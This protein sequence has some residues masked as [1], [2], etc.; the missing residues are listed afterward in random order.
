MMKEIKKIIIKILEDN[1][2]I[3]KKSLKERVGV[4]DLPFKRAFSEL[5]RQ[6]TVY[7]DYKNG[8]CHLKSDTRNDGRI[9]NDGRTRDD[10]REKTLISTGNEI[11]DVA[12]SFGLTRDFGEDVLAQTNGC[13]PPGENELASR[14]TLFDKI[15]IT[16]D[17][18]DSKDLDDAVSLETL[19]NGNKILGVHIADVSHY[20]TRGSALDIEARNRGTSVYLINKVIPMLPTKLSNEICSLNPHEPRLTLSCFMEIDH[21]GRVLAHTL[22]KTAI[23]SK[24]RMTYSNVNKIL[25]GNDELRGSYADIVPILE[26]M[27]RLS[28][29]VRRRRQDAGC[30][31][32]E[33]DECKIE[34]DENDMP[35]EIGVRER[36]DAEKLI[37]DFMIIANETV[38]SDFFGAGYP[39]IY[40]VHDRPES[41]KLKNLAEFL[42]TLGIKFNPNRSNGLRG[43]T[44]LGRDN[45]EQA[46]INRMVLRAMQKA[47]YHTK[48]IGHFGL[49]STA[50][51][52]FTSP[53]RRYPDL[54]VH[55]LISARLS[56]EDVKRAEYAGELAVI[57]AHSSDMERNAIDAERAVDA[58]KKTQ[59]M[60]E[61][62]GETFKGVVSGMSA[63]A[64]YVELPNTVEGVVPMRYM[65]DDYYIV[66]RDKYCAIGE[67]TRRRIGLGDEVEVRAEN[68]KLNVPEVVFSIGNRPAGRKYGDSKPGG[69]KPGNNKRGGRKPSD[70]K[71]SGRKHVGKSGHKRAKK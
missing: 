48:N 11:F 7:F 23:I 52:H 55:R 69:H 3:N 17:G 64:L 47:V 5:K 68:A 36:G 44:D 70:H 33:I 32:F 41:E 27:Q 49:G 56:G 37:E 6:G 42:K 59:Y 12:Q 16:I 38:A 61:Y 1:S 25:D 26:D 63:G 22:E 35:V 24:H 21:E 50:Y 60:V 53:I 58:L 10:G 46:I 9:R 18:D 51:C 30:I 65:L 8:T 71:R 28:R 4:D 19:E 20:V 31:D 54:I 40:R 62:V 45:T 34:L 29:V 67:N 43:V 13:T 66:H 2:G 15:V 57:A 39:L 14:R